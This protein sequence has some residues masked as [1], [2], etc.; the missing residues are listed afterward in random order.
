MIYPYFAI[1]SYTDH[2][3]ER[4]YWGLYGLDFIRDQFPDN[5]QAIEWINKNIS[6]QPVMLEAVGD[7]YTSFN[8]VSMATGLPTVEGWIVHEW[9]WRGGYD[10]PAGRQIDVQQIYESE[11]LE[12]VKM[13]LQKY[14]VEYIFIGDNEYEKYPNLN[15]SNFAQLGQVVFT[16]V[17]LKYTNFTNFSFYLLAC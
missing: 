16:S 4:K 14:N 11:D 3:L 2:H 15:E 5:F 17:I 10:L 1:K 12:I 13:L 7:S 9:L 8:H 6:G